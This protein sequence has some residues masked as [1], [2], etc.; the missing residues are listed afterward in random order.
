LNR[1]TL[2]PNKNKG[3]KERFKVKTNI[4][5]YCS[6]NEIVFRDILAIARRYAFWKSV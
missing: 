1:Q 4:C 3:L 6:R 2:C 5:S